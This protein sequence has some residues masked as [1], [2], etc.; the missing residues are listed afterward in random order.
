MK[1]TIAILIFCLLA[2]TGFGCQKD[3]SS[4]TGVDIPSGWKNFESSDYGFS[5]AYP[6][7]MEMR[8]RAIEQQDSTYVGLQGNF[9]ASLRD[10]ERE[11]KPVSIAA[12]YAFKD[13]SVE[14]FIESLQASDPDNITIKET[15][16]LSQ[17]GLAMK[18][19]VNTTALGTDK[20]HYVFSLN[21]NLIVIS[22]FLEEDGNFAPLVSTMQVLVE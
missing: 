11:E 20:T 12:F 13:L 10:P 7:N 19:I 8:A 21:G 16:D 22:V 14:K 3:N 2:I 4:N 18:K 9:F 1:K 6:N 15:S 17:G 5:I